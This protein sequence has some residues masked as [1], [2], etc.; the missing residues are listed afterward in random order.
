MLLD[1]G[2]RTAQI[3]AALA[4]K[5]ESPAIQQDEGAIHFWRKDGQSFYRPL[6]DD[7]RL[8]LIEA[9]QGKKFS[10]IS[11]TK[12]A[13]KTCL[14]MVRGWARHATVDSKL[15]PRAF[16]AAVPARRLWPVK[17]A[18]LRLLYGRPFGVDHADAVDAHHVGL[19]G[20]TLVDEGYVADVD[21]RAVDRLHRKAID[22]VEYN[23]TGIE[24]DIPVERAGFQV[25]S[26]RR[27]DNVPAGLREKGCEA[28][29]YFRASMPIS[30]SVA[31]L[32]RLAFSGFG[33]AP[34]RIAAAQAG[35][36]TRLL[37]G[38]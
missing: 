16:T 18:I 6:A 19:R 4:A 11:L 34:E 33:F 25:P 24:R 1:L 27:R 3:Y 7:E 8:A 21:Y 5:E 31:G 36:I 20:G 14:A 37:N 10:D 15:K 30:I 22:L 28:P 29:V 23:R 12:R 35:W 38:S 17:S 32:L 13:T 9:R 26:A 2:R